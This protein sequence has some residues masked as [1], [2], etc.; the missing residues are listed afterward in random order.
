MFSTL[1]TLA[2]AIFGLGYMAIGAWIVCFIAPIS[3]A[4]GL[5]DAMGL[6]F[7]LF[8]ALCVFTASLR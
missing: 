5:L 1:K 8:G 4:H 2:L 7:S 6:L 3:S